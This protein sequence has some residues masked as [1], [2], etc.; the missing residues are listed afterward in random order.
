MNRDAGIGIRYQEP[1]FDGERAY[2]LVEELR[3]NPEFTNIEETFY[4]QITNF[5]QSIVDSSVR[6]NA[7]VASNAGIKTMVIRTAS[8]KAC[9]WCAEVA[10]QYDYETVKNTGNDVWRRH[11]N[12]NCTIDYVTE[13]NSRLYRERVYG[14]NRESVGGNEEYR[15]ID[16]QSSSSDRRDYSYLSEGRA[17]LTAHEM[18][19]LSRVPDSGEYHKFNIGYITE[20]DM[21]RLSAYT[22]HEMAL[23]RSKHDEILFH[24]DSR[25]CNPPDNMQ[26]ELISKYEWIAHTHV[27]G[28]PLV[29]SAADRDTLKEL[30]QKSSTLLGIDG[31][32]LDFTENPF[33]QI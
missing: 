30:G 32:R 2:G 3:S 23:W 20:Q 11:E 21:S 15:K 33:D 10:G 4:D 1:A 25:T 24:G 22:H 31:S 7:E 19:I 16:I 12:C 14:G 8:S 9:Q 5:S 6:A 13:R 17:G 26:D 29:P 27:D 28:G 18:S